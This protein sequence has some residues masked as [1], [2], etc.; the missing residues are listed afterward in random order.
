MIRH[1]LDMAFSS[2]IEPVRRW[3]SE[4]GIV[5][6]DHFTA[7]DQIDFWIAVNKYVVGQC[8]EL[9]AGRHYILNFDQLCT[10]PEQE[11]E[12]LFD[13]LGINSRASIDDLSKLVALPVSTGRYRSHLHTF[14]P[15][16]IQAVRDFGFVVE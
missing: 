6:T 3:G 5:N 8:Q 10:N 12:K 11:I 2:N 13:F 7:Q 16:Q 1:G 4:F 14:T 9:F 15:E